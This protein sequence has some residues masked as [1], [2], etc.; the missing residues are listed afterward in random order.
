[1]PNVIIKDGA[2]VRWPATVNSL[3]H[4]AQGVSIPRNAKAPITAGGFTLMTP[5][6]TAAPVNDI[7]RETAPI[8]IDSVVTQQWHSAAF[9]AEELDV[10][11][12]Q[13]VAQILARQQKEADAGVLLNGLLVDTRRSAV[14]ELVGAVDGMRRARV[15]SRKINIGG[16]RLE[17][18]VAQ[19]EAMIDAVDD[20]R[21]ACHDRG[22]SLGELVDAA[23]DKAAIDLIS[24]N[25]GWPG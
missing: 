9:T 24:I 22:F 6:A 17:V 5:A 3:R 16:G 25:E 11:R 14:A 4:L 18:N 10:Y 19:L 1:M 2:V 12:A 7:V 15:S 20:H 13:I 8:F 21:Q 23:A